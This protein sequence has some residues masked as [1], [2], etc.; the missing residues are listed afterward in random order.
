MKKCILI[1]IFIVIS[2]L[3]CRKI[4]GCGVVKGGDYD[5][6]SNNTYSYYLWIKFP[7]SSRER[8]VYVDY[9]IFLDYR[10][11]TEICF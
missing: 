1:T 9:K 5:T 11:G 6:N 10:I 8:K 3:G 4:D 7:D 2:L